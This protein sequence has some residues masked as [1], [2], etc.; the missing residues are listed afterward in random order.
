MSAVS[1]YSSVNSAIHIII[2]F[3]WKKFQNFMKLNNKPSGAAK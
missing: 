1:K 3:T 2:S